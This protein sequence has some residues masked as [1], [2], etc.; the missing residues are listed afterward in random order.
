MI[1]KVKITH[2]DNTP[3]KYLGQTK[4]LPEGSEYEFKSGVNVIVGPNGTG[5]STLLKLIKKYILI[6]RDNQDAKNVDGLFDYYTKSDKDED[7]MFDGIDVYSDY[8]L[9]SFNFVHM[10]E[11]LSLI[12]I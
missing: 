1:T 5:K 9:A 4:I 3:I 6:D 7:H 12:H 11:L 8:R 2:R 10:D